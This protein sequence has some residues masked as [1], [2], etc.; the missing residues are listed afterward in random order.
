MDLPCGQT[1]KH[2]RFKTGPHD[3]VGAKDLRSYLNAANPVTSCPVM[4]RWMSCVPS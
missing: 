2:Q 4:S 1:G 3:Q